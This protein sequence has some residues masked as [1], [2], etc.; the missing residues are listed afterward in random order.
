[1]LVRPHAMRRLRPITTAGRPGIV[2]PVTVKPGLSIATRYHRAGARNV[3]WGSLARIGL[4]ERV[5]AGPITHEFDARLIA[6]ASRISAASAGM[7]GI[8]LAASRAVGRA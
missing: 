2:A 8:S 3:R 5:R 6:E 1:M 7:C 4:P